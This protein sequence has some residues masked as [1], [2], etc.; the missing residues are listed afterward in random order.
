MFV[1]SEDFFEVSNVPVSYPSSPHLHLSS[2][3]RSSLTC[4]SRSTYSSCV[5]PVHHKEIYF[6][7][8][9][10]FKAKV[11]VKSVQGGHILA[12]IK[13]PEFSLC[14]ISFPCVIFTQK[15]TISSMNKGHITTV[16][17]QTEAYKLIF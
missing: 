5:S 12:K 4:R 1:N 10:W 17:L 13:F 9:K 7:Y 3:D 14:Y 16:L 6:R 11:T 15:L 8:W 2:L